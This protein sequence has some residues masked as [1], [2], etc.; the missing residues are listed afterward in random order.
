M[1]YYIFH[2]KFNK[3]I[4]IFKKGKNI[5]LNLFAKLLLEGFSADLYFRKFNFMT[6]IHPID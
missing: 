4:F 2:E 1:K 6:H 5:N 3:I